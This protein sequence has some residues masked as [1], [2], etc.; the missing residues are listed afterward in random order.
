MENKMDGEKI[1]SQLRLYLI[2]KSKTNSCMA[3]CFLIEIHPN[4]LK[5]LQS[6]VEEEMWGINLSLLLSL[7]KA[8]ACW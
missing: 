2:S 8:V 7:V 3:D 4:G 1:N 6:V 5:S